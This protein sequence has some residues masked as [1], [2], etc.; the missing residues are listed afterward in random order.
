MQELKRAKAPEDDGGKEGA[1]N[2]ENQGEDD[3]IERKSDRMSE[4]D[5]G[6]LERDL[7][8]IRLQ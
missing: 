6:A 2:K 7:L 8:R 5:L 3:P 4:F 1:A